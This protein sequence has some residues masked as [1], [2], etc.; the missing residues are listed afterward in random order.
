MVREELNSWF[1]DPIAGHR[2]S[3]T[4]KLERYSVNQAGYCTYDLKLKYAGVVYLGIVSILTVLYRK[5]LKITENGQPRI[6][7]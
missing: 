5:M 1:L 2:R 3:G 7:I 6:T 4:I